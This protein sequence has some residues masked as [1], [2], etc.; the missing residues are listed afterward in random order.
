MSVFRQKSW[1]NEQ[2]KWVIEEL[3]AEAAKGSVFRWRQ[4][5]FLALYVKKRLLEYGWSWQAARVDNWI[6]RLQPRR[7][8]S[9]QDGEGERLH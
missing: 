8:D 2:L 5:L 4:G 9:Q 7:A 1:A 6:H 3:R